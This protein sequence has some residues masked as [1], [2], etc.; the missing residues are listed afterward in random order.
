MEEWEK[1][2]KSREKAAARE[3]IRRDQ[4][5]ADNAMKGKYFG[6]HLGPGNPLQ[7][8]EETA[9]KLRDTKRE[10]YKLRKDSE[11]MGKKVESKPKVLDTTHNLDRDVAL[12]PLKKKLKQEELAFKRKPEN[13]KFFEGPEV[14]KWG[15]LKKVIRKAPVM[16]TLMDASLSGLEKIQEGDYAGAGLDIAEATGRTLA[17]MASQAFDAIKPTTIQASEARPGDPDIEAIKKATWG[18][19]Q[20]KLQESQPTQEDE[21]NIQKG[22][23]KMM[24]Q[25]GIF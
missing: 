4:R 10:Q 18:S 3:Q 8:D 25:K 12:D 6:A 20:D 7:I 9:R 24:L 2:K 16:G 22:V 15:A 13:K 14:G 23:R 21:N 1:D 11:Q 5:V 19:L 17:P